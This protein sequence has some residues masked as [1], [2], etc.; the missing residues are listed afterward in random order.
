MGKTDRNLEKETAGIISGGLPWLL[1]GAVTD[2][3]VQRS[4]QVGT[5]AH[6][7]S[8]KDLLWL[9]GHSLQ[10]VESTEETIGAEFPI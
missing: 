1:K 2:S 4:P 3:Y 5:M 10:C 9:S 7:L 6:A 8:E